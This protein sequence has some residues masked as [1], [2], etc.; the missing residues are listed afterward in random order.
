MNFR[1]LESLER[2]NCAGTQLGGGG[3]RETYGRMGKNILRN[4]S[5]GSIRFYA[6][7]GLRHGAA[8]LLES[9]ASRSIE[10]HAKFIED[11]YPLWKWV[12]KTVSY[13]T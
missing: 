8:S 3:A 2:E 6:I 10:Q 4:L 13:R 7:R 11:A 5:D 9:R 1:Y 12:Q